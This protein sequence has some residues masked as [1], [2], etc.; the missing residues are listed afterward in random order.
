MFSWNK[1]FGFLIWSSVQSHPGSRILGHRGE[2]TC[3]WKS[4][5]PR[6]G[7]HEGSYERCNK[8]Q[9][10]FPTAPQ[11]HIFS[12]ANNCSL[13]TPSPFLHLSLWQGVEAA[14]SF[15]SRKQHNI[16]R[17]P[18][19]PPAFHRGCCHWGSGQAWPE[20]PSF[21]RTEVP[22]LRLSPLCSLPSQSLFSP[23]LSLFLWIYF[24]LYFS[25]CLCSP[26]SFCLPLPCSQLCLGWVPCSQ[27]YTL[28]LNIAWPHSSSALYIYWLSLQ[29]S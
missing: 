3:F 2:S 18:A 8:S 21:P 10:R 20:R 14:E 1:S 25:Y 29:I 9:Q 28:L 26:H 23:P 24:F 11:P 15:T 17:G 4:G 22:S 5:L 16:T 12:A 27:S 7:Q 6:T 19:A 13:H